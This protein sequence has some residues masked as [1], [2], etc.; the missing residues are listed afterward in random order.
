[1]KHCFLVIVALVLSFGAAQAQAQREDEPS[2]DVYFYFVKGDNWV[3]GTDCHLRLTGYANFSQGFPYA[4]L[5]VNLYNYDINQPYVRSFGYLTEI[6]GTISIAGNLAYG[7]KTFD[8][9]VPANTSTVCIYV[10]IT[11]ETPVVLEP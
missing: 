4:D 3:N 2:V 1:M 7:S 8:V 6:R 5:N 10:D 9:Q 11:S